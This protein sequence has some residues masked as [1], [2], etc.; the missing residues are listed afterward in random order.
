MLGSGK[1]PGKRWRKSADVMTMVPRTQP[2]FPISF[3]MSPH[4]LVLLD[5]RTGDVM[6]WLFTNGAAPP[7][8]VWGEERHDGPGN[9]HDTL[10]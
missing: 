4:P 8:K 1:R 9:S 7:E 6:L 5:K 10:G 3:R 2:S